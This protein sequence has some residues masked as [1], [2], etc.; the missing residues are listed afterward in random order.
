MPTERSNPLTVGSVSQRAISSPQLASAVTISG[1]SRASV[2]ITASRSA[3]LASAMPNLIA[4]SVSRVRSFP[5]STMRLMT[6]SLS[7]MASAMSPR[8]PL[9]SAVAR[10]SAR[11]Y[12]TIFSPTASAWPP[13]ATWMGVAAPIVPPSVMMMLSQARLINAPALIARGWMNATVRGSASSNASRIWIAASTRPPS[14]L[15][16]ITI[17]TASGLVS[18]ARRTNAARPSS[19][20]RSIAMTTTLLPAGASIGRAC[21]SPL[22]L[23]LGAGR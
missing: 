7:T 1:S 8:L 12:D 5:A 18:M 6:T 15:T 23:A 21:T 16:S 10:I 9:A 4:W 13:G 17:A 19:T 3:A 14:V 11:M 2:C 22:T 20:V